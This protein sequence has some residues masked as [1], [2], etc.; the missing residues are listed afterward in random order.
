MCVYKTF[1]SFPI[2]SRNNGTAV[3]INLGKNGWSDGSH[4]RKIASC[5]ILDRVVRP[6]AR[7]H[8]SFRKISHRHL[9]LYNLH[10]FLKELPTRPL[11]G[12]GGHDLS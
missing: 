3:A 2:E 12:G 4:Y 5:A 11:E 7:T 9:S 8:N 6:V 10:H 1:S